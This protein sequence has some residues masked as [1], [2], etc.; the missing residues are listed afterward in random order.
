M[1]RVYRL[2]EALTNG[3]CF[4]GGNPIK[5]LNVDWFDSEAPF[6]IPTREQVEEEVRRKR[7]FTDDAAFLV[8][9]DR[10]EQ[11]F[12]IWPKGRAA[13]KLAEPSE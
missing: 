7:Y 1:I 8:L 11:T 3:Y 6:G 13:L 2:P 12:V 9:S 10:D 5:F 4:S